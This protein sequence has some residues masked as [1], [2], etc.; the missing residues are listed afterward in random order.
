MCGIEEIGLSRSSCRSSGTGGIRGRSMSGP[1][2]FDLRDGRVA[3]MSTAGIT[4]L[5]CWSD[6]QPLAGSSR[7]AAI[8]AGPG[9]YRARITGTGEVVYIGQTG[10]SL[11]ERLGMLATCYRSE[12][13]YRDPHTA[14]PTLWSLRD[15]DGVDFEVSTVVIDSTKVERLALEAVAVTLHRVEHGRSPVANFGGRIAGYRISSG[16]NASLV[17]AGKRL[18][19]GRD[20][21]AEA[22]PSAPIPGP[23][24]REVTASDWI[25]LGWS[26]WVPVDAP[27]VAP[28]IGLYRLRHR[29]TDD[30]LYVG[31][32]RV[33]AR[34]R[35]HQ[36]KRSATEH[37]QANLFDGDVEASWVVLQAEG[38]VL[39]ELENDAIASHRIKRGSAPRAQ[40]L[41]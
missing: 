35:A 34:V 15:R 40:F 13:R 25:G 21:L 36:A 29:G 33:G 20:P 3:S 22:S 23:L 38:R 31:Q 12:M 10:R 37:R 1:R 6:W 11:R 4:S 39:L 32:G 14:A 27:F 19:G 5:T 30:L 24:D 26:E 8:P 18:R 28:A 7:K 17:A 41:G 9:L 2:R 16:N